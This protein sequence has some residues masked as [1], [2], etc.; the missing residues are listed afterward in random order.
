MKKAAIEQKFQQF[1]VAL[2]KEIAEKN[3]LKTYIKQLNP[4]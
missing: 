4:N 3:L 1:K 2:P